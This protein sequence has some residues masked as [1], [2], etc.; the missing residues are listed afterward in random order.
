MELVNEREKAQE[1]R[2]ARIQ[3]GRRNNPAGMPTRARSSPGGS[4]PVPDAVCS[5]LVAVALTLPRLHAAGPNDE[6]DGEEGEDAGGA[7][8]GSGGR[9]RVGAWRPSRN[10]SLGPRVTCPVPALRALCV[11]V[12][13]QYADC[14]ESL[15]GVPDAMR[16]T[17]AVAC[18]ARRALTPEVRC[19]VPLTTGPALWWN[20][21]GHRAAARHAVPCVVAVRAPAGP[22]AHG[23]RWRWC[24]RATAPVSCCYPT[25][26]SWTRRTWWSWCRR[27][28]RPGQQGHEGPRH[29][30]RGVPLARGLGLRWQCAPGAACRLE[31]LELG[32]CGR[33][34][35]DASQKRATGVHGFRE[36][37]CSAGTAPRHPTRHQPRTCPWLHV[38]MRGRMGD[39]TCLAACAFTQRSLPAA[40]VLSSSSLP[41]GAAGAAG[42]APEVEAAEALARAAAQCPGGV[43]PALRRLKLGGAYRLNTQGLAQV[44]VLARVCGRGVQE[45]RLQRAWWPRVSRA[46]V[47]CLAAVHHRDWARRCCAWRPT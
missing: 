5:P 4:A 2:R 10:P 26:P 16:S 14:L 11:S 35:G 27:Q 13:V 41:A 21:A 15:A 17:L 20:H 33:G 6:E 45:G 1:R 12:L 38:L 39:V 34:F 30:G 44:R 28:P 18:C 29:L 47:P 37:V 36:G 25:A 9:G 7:E 46:G 23:L 40:P 42:A 31:R 43:L 8:G 19:G 22:R 32:M 24:L 3:E